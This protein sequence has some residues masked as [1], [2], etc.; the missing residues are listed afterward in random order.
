MRKHIIFYLIVIALLLVMLS[1]C[2]AKEAPF[3]RTTDDQIPI[4]EP[5]AVGCLAPPDIIG[6]V[7]EV[8]ANNNVRVLIDSKGDDNTVISG[9]IWVTIDEKTTFL[10]SLDGNEVDVSDIA[11]YFI[12]GNKVTILSIGEIM[13]SYP[14]QTTALCVYQTD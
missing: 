9:Q 3:R 5:A 7:L 10:E 4:D 6:E 12:V 2:N 1:G 11:S 8:T 13:E 14:M